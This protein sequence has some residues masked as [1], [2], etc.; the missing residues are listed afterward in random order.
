MTSVFADTSFFVALLV[1]RDLFHAEAT[2][3]LTTLTARIV[4]TDWVLVETA[5]YM[6]RSKARHRVAGFLRGLQADTRF[7]FVPASAAAIESGLRMYE[8]HQDKHWSLTDCI[9]FQVMRQE[10][11][12]QA[13]TADHHFEQAG[14]EILLK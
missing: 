10:R 1:L 2:K 13:L 9:S 12:S 4:T 14:F 6:A 5:N 7:D 3:L 8:Q 11:I